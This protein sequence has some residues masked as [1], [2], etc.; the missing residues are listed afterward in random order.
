VT[1]RAQLDALVHEM[2]AKG[3]LYEDASREFE[4]RFVAYAL[5]ESDGNIGRA[6]ERIGLH[7]NT[8]SRKLD[9]YGLKKG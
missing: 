7:R 5:E 1:I 9:E 8:F 2:V 3:V 6:A 4:R